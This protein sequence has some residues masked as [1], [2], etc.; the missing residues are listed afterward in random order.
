MNP[1]LQPWQGCTLPLSYS[2]STKK[3]FTAEALFCQALFSEMSPF[4]SQMTTCRNNISKTQALLRDGISW[5]AFSPRRFGRDEEKKDLSM[6]KKGRK[7][8][9][10]G[11][12]IT[13]EGTPQAQVFLRSEGGI[14]AQGADDLAVRGRAHGNVQKG[15]HGHFFFGTVEQT[16]AKVG[17]FL[18]AGHGNG[19]SRRPAR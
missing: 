10:N 18:H 9:S 14:R 7:P 15:V 8:I 17:V 12:P 5:S 6:K 19:P 2:R 1:R 4:S 16:V 3:R 11:P 13:K